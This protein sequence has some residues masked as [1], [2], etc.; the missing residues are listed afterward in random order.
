M[1]QLIALA[2]ILSASPL[3]AQQV[4]SVRSGEH[5]GFSRLVLQIDPDVSWEI[6]EARGRASV[7]FPEQALSFST[8]QVFERIS[9]DRIAGINQTRT[10]V[11]S[12]L[13]IEM[14]CACGVQSFAFNDKYIVIDVFDGPD[15]AAVEAVASTPLWQPDALPF[16]QPPNTPLRFLAFVM[17]QAP[18]QPLLLPDQPAKADQT[19]APQ[20]AVP[21]LPDMAANIDPADADIVADMDS[22]IGAVVSDMNEGVVA[23]DNPEMLARIAEAQ[24]QLLAQLTRAADQGLVNFVPVP[25]P[26][27]VAEEQPTAPIPEPE[28]PVLTAELMQQLSART[29]YSQNTEDA[30][31]DIVNQFAMPQCLD[32]AIFSMEGWGG[33]ASFSSQLASLRSQFLGEFDT[34]DAEIAESIVQLYLRYGFGAEARLMLN[35]AGVELENAPLY[36]DMAALVEGEPAWVYGPALK[37]AGCGGAHEMWYLATGLGDYQVLEPLSITD[38]FSNYPIEVRTQIGPPLAQAFINRGQVDAGHVVLEIVRRAES[39]VTPAQRMAEAHVMELQG[40]SSGAARVY[41]ALALGNEENAPEALIAYARTLLASDKSLPESLLVDLESA[42]FFNRNTEKADPLRLW[43]I[44]VRAAVAGANAGLHQIAENLEERPHI[45][46]ELKAIAAEIFEAT[47][48]AETGDY[49]YAQMVLRFAEILEQGALGD[50]ARLKIAAEMATVGLPESALDVLAPNL[51]RATPPAKRIEA[52][53]FVQL[54]QPRQALAILDGD[55]SLDAYKIRLRANLQLEDFVAVAEMLNE[56]HAKDISVNDVALRAGD[57]EKIKDAGAVGTLASYIQGAEPQ[58][59]LPPMMAES[60]PT[61]KAARALLADNQ[62]SMRFLEDM[63][64]DAE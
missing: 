63:L 30:L 18:R 12:E 5:D 55:E 32:D 40:D 6:I 43:E 36:N 9:T 57:W 25:V 33:E 64:A 53:A 14:N 60:A 11:G 38:V 50:A 62:E 56:V 10:D 51:S 48:A 39:G 26:V 7:R 23:E 4:V 24:T 58:E 27:P 49:A 21:A 34:P 20:M 41:R 61:L 19:P 22:M 45:S 3:A 54:F 15:L 46:A 44:K 47:S 42:A 1:K 52:A 2:L 37:G 35:E 29:A 31:S 28:P 59:E 8:A 16:V 17:A 13:H